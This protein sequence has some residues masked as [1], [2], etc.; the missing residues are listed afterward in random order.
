M[1]AETHH[2][3]AD[4]VLESKDHAD[5]YNHDCQSDSHSCRGNADGWSADFATLVF[6][7]IDSAG[8]E[9]GQIHSSLRPG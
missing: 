9:Q 3:V 5:G 4:G 1:T 8:Y 6:R 7:A 2:F